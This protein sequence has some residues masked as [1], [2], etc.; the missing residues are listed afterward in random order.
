[1]SLRSTFSS[2]LDTWSSFGPGQFNERS[3][4]LAP[5]QLQ[6]YGSLFDAGV[7]TD[8]ELANLL[9]FAADDTGR[10]WAWPGSGFGDEPPVME[11]PSRCLDAADV[12]PVA[13]DVL[14][15]LDS[16]GDEPLVPYFVPAGPL[17]LWSDVALLSPGEHLYGDQN[18]VA[19]A[20]VERW[21]AKM[22]DQE[23][24]DTCMACKVYLPDHCL[25]LSLQTV[26][27]EITRAPTDS[28]LRLRWLAPAQP[29]VVGELV[30]L[31]ESMGWDRDRDRRTTYCWEAAEEGVRPELQRLGWF[32]S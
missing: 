21:G 16:W 8:P 12:R 14:Q 24:A 28:T 27:A 32:A 5:N 26:S 2:Y 31:L 20:L 30:T 13:D 19:E 11:I 29:A 4:L 9:L 23:L 6:T 25:L 15:L 1:M 22:L 3:W 17:R 18:A 7:V 10:Y